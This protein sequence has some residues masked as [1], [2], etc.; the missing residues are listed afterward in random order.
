MNKSAEWI[1]YR[2]DGSKD[3]IDYLS[4]GYRLG[5]FGRGRVIR[6]GERITSIDRKK[7]LKSST[8][9]PLTPRD[10]AAFDADFG[11]DELCVNRLP[12][13]EA[14]ELTIE[15]VSKNILQ[16]LDRLG[17]KPEDVNG[18]LVG[19]S[20]KPIDGGRPSELYKDRLGLNNAQTFDA[21]AACASG[22]LAFLKALADPIFRYKPCIVVGIE[23]MLRRQTTFDPRKVDYGS[24]LLF[25]QAAAITAFIPGQT[26]SLNR[27]TLTYLEKPDLKGFLPAN[28]NYEVDPNF[29]YQVTQ[30]DRD[31]IRV[32]LPK[33]E[34]ALI[35]MQ[36]EVGAFFPEPALATVELLRGQFAQDEWDNIQAMVTHFPSK[37][38]VQRLVAGLARN[39]SLPKG[40]AE[41]Y[42]PSSTELE[43]FENDPQLFI[44]NKW[45]E[46][47]TN[48]IPDSMPIY[49]KHGRM[50]NAPAANTLIALVENAQKLNNRDTLFLTFGAGA[51]FAAGVIRIS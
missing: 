35:D 5:T 45:R 30:L 23:D 8:S 48:G 36:A 19:S 25:T 6:W 34:R 51:S 13:N 27:D 10:Q 29:G 28:V 14:Q 44:R 17:W 32:S 47:R 18:I 42:M 37:F 49:P 43:A 16:T 3:R 2:P 7:E 41:Q 38:I 39:G 26:I 22:G 24:A 33:P 40:I 21:H 20:L 12:E 46:I 31:E 50:G 1:K 4:S 9:V 11:V 15:V